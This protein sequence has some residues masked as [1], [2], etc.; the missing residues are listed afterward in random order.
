MRAR[1]FEAREQS[2]RHFGLVIFQVVELFQIVELLDVRY[3]QLLRCGEGKAEDDI[4]ALKAADV[5]SF[6]LVKTFVERSP[7]TVRTN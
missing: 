4:P 7:A 3:C 2:T 1:R 6:T 5:Q